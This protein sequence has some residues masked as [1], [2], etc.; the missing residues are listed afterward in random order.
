MKIKKVAIGA[1]A[2]MVA[3]A[4]T[5]LMEQVASAETV[6]F[7]GTVGFA[8]CLIN[9]SMLSDNSQQNGA[10]NIANPNRCASQVAVRVAWKDAPGHVKPGPWSVGPRSADAGTPQGVAMSGAC[11]RALVGGDFYYWQ[12]DGT[13]NVVAGS[14]RYPD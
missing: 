5:V 10:A 11:W 4:P 7:Q 3:A 2:V 14:C 13:T 6:I 9:I 1:T 8:G 12:N